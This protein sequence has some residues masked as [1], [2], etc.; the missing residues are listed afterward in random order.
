MSETHFHRHLVGGPDELLGDLAAVA[1]VAVRQ[2]GV[3]IGERR[4]V[5]FIDGN[6][7][8]TTIADDSGNEEVDVTI[9]V[10][11]SELDI[12][13][14]GG[15]L[16]HG[17]LDGLAD[18]DHNQYLNTTRHDVL[19]ARHDLLPWGSLGRATTS[20]GQ[21]GISTEANVTALSVTVTVGTSRVVRVST[22]GLLLKQ[23][24]A[25]IVTTRIKESTT[26]LALT[27]TTQGIGAY[28]AMV[29]SV[30]LTPSAGSHTYNVTLAATPN[31]VDLVAVHAYILAEDI[32][33]A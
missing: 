17:D 27:N 8:D 5:N 25:G 22:F 26:A 21:T 10:D 29:A 19:A 12:A 16:D 7:I 33:P 9:A 20:A 24:G 15:T 28:A 32:G 6:G 1:R 31:T 2:G 4:A 14:M 3:L 23:T 13:T 18:D 11:E 30:I